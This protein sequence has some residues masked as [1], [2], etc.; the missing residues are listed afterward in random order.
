MWINHK[1]WQIHINYLFQ[2]VGFHCNIV[3][4]LD[5]QQGLLHHL[6]RQIHHILV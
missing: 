3:S 6:I 2:R 5:A 4:K 1:H